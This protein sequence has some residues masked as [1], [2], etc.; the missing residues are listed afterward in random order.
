MTQ[1]IISSTHPLDIQI[2]SNTID[3]YGSLGMANLLLS[4][5]SSFFSG[6][7]LAQSSLIY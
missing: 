2:A 5:T 4:K 1:L 6:R 7:V 3:T